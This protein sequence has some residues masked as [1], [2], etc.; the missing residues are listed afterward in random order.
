MKPVLTALKELGR[1]SKPQEV[2]QVIAKNEHLTEE[3]LSETSGKNNVNKF[4]NEV[5]FARN[6]L[7]SG[8]YID[9]STY[10]MWI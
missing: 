7:V 10:G 2:R 8:G 9:K 6:Y 1:Q 5:A 3:E 4:E